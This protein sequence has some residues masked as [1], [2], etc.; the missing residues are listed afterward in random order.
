MAGRDQA[1]M[2][3]EIGDLLFTVVNLSRQ[4]EVHPHQALERTN[5]K[6][7]RRFKAMEK[8]IEQRGQ[9]LGELSLEELDKFWMRSKPKSAGRPSAFSSCAPRRKSGGCP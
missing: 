4:L 3:E 2:E 6:F 7:I 5:E 8:L 1:A 9:I